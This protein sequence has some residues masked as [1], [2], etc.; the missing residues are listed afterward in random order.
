MT[1]TDNLTPL[2]IREL[3]THSFV[4]PKYQRGYRWTTRQVIELLD[5]VLAFVDA[6]AGGFYCLQP[7]V[8]TQR[9]LR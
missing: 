6:A 9:E 5:D 1:K 7:I 2:A 8:V 4:V 3:M